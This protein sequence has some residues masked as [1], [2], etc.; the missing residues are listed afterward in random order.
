MKSSFFPFYIIFILL[1][2]V[3]LSKLSANEKI[4][5]SSEGSDDLFR[6]IEKHQYFSAF[7][8]QSTLQENNQRQVLGTIKANRSG[9]FKISYLEPL[10]EIM[11]SDGVD[12]YHLDPELEQLI[13]EPLENLLK[14]TPVGI[15]ALKEEEIK[16]LFL[17]KEC[18]KTKNTFSCMLISKNK[19]SFIKWI[20]IKTKDSTI[21]SLEYIDTFGQKVSLHFKDVSMTRISDNEFQLEIPEGIDIVS[22]KV[23]KQ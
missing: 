8:T 11:L 7:F 5:N 18:K 2:T 20:N 1:S 3:F 4:G 19:E 9:K 12:F 16:K 22:Y 14:D 23:N 21:D 6:I 17:V 13:I 15:F 10:N